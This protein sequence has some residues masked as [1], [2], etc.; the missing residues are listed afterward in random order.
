M[1]QIIDFPIKELPIGLSKR[2]SEEA[3]STY[4]SQD[5]KGLSYSEKE[6]FIDLIMDWP[7]F[8]NIDQNMKLQDL[9]TMYYEDELNLSQDCA[10]EF[11]FHMHDPNSSF[12]IGN[13]LYTWDQ[14]DREFFILNLKMHAN[15]I[16][17]I[18][19]EDS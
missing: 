13:A 17:Q 10:L 3:F 16:D 11:M 7:C 1:G 19:E 12:D 15:L 18:K 14:Q 2:T 8:Q 4:S 9:L 5:L 6:A